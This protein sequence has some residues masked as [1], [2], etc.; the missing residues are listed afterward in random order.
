MNSPTER[1]LAAGPSPVGLAPHEV[2]ALAR[3]AV[4][5]VGPDALFDSHCELM[6]VLKGVLCCIEYH[7]NDSTLNRRLLDKLDAMTLAM[8]NATR[9]NPRGVEAGE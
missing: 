3:T 1:I 4:Q 8:G 2:D 5:V 6:R 9:V 7:A